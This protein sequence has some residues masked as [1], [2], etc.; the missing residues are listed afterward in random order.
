LRCGLDGALGACQAAVY[1][2]LAEAD[3]HPD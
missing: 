3:L 1:E 2:S